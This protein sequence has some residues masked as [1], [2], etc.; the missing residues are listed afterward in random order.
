MSKIVFK[1]LSDKELLLDIADSSPVTLVE[2]I[3]ENLLSKGLVE[4]LDRSTVSK[5]FFYKNENLDVADTLIKSLEQLIKQNDG[6]DGSNKKPLNYRNNLHQIRLNNEKNRIKDLIMHSKKTGKTLPDNLFFPK[7]GEM[8]HNEL[9]GDDE[10]K[11]L[12]NSATQEVE[13]QLAS[14]QTQK[15]KNLTVKPMKDPSVN[16]RMGYGGFISPKRTSLETKVDTV[17]KK[18]GSGSGGASTPPMAPTPTVSTV[19]TTAPSQPNIKDLNKSNYGPRGFG[20]YSEVDNIKRKANNVGDVMQDIGPNR[21][22]KAFST[23]PGQLSAKQQAN[24]EAKKLNA[25]NRK[26]PVTTFSEMSEEK[27]EELRQMYEK[28]GNKGE[29]KKSWANHNPIPSV[30]Q[31]SKNSENSEIVFTNQ[32]VKMMQDRQML[33]F[34]QPT[35]DDFIASG[36]QM[37]LGSTKELVKKEQE[38]FNSSINNW[39]KE[40]TKPISQRFSSEE[41][42]LAYWNN[43]K[44]PDSSE[45]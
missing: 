29:I 34:K 28:K 19:Q 3:V 24:Q 13:K 20:Q 12:F 21:N 1:Q 27:K 37:G 23:K 11:E 45:E 14:M 30:S 2:N 18:P 40:A 26:A 8:Y 44:V 43:I 15:Q 16:P 5:R 10:R 6:G 36:E 22:V 25:A 7:K 41:E 32:L 38:S 31:T 33:N 42:E 39:L 17:N 9:I 4:D 35:N